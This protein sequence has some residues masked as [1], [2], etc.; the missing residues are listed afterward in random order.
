MIETALFD[1]DQP[2]DRSMR[3]VIVRL[4]EMHGKGVILKVKDIFNTMDTG[5]KG[6]VSNKEFGD[7]LKMLSK[8]SISDEECEIVINRCDVD[9]SGGIDYCEFADLCQRHIERDK[10]MVNKDVGSFAKI[11]VLSVLVFPS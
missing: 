11:E 2:F 8:G 7:V 1:Q 5:S 9:A 6:C 10:V 3:K 4:H